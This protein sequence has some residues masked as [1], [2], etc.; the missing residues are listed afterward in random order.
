MSLRNPEFGNIWR[1]TRNT[2]IH[3]TLGGTLHTFQAGKPTWEG[4]SFKFRALNSDQVTELKTF[5]LQN[6]GEIVTLTDFENRQWTGIVVSESV[7][8]V[9]GRRNPRVGS[10][11]YSC[12]FEMSFD[13]QGNVL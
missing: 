2:I 7:K 6:A 5:L 8:I 13:F 3:R 12:N 4:F 10:P 9:K 1:L 11:N